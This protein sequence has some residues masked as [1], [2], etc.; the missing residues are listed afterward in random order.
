MHRKP[1]ILY[2]IPLAVLGGTQSHL[3]HLLKGFSHQY[4]IHLGIGEEGPLTEVAKSLNITVHLLPHL[5]RDINL[6]ADLKAIQET[7]ALIRSLQPDFIHTHNSKAGLVG[8][9]AGRLCGTPVIYT[10]HGWQFAAGTPL[11]HKV[12]SYINEKIGAFLSYK[13]ICVSE[14]DRKLA[15]RRF[16]SNRQK[17]VTIH[18]GIEDNNI[19][20]SHPDKTP[21]KVVMVARFDKQKD[22][23]TL[24]QSITQ[25]LH[26][27]FSVD[28]IGSGP[29]LPDCV[30][31]VEEL[32]LKHTVNFLGNRHDVP[33]I[34]SKAQL[35]VLSTNYE[36]LPI[37]ILEAMRAG[38]PV[39]A[40]DVD[41]IPE[42][43]IDGESGLLVP[44][45]DIGKMAYALEKLLSSPTIR[46]DMGDF[47]R[48]TFE[49]Q[50]SLKR[51]L[52]ETQS[53]YQEI[54]PA[55]SL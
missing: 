8:R 42:E 36:G 27:Q 3:C 18:L 26:L 23:F 10:A 14:S 33:E 30:A 28:L 39:V 17:I 49:N 43:V 54:I 52:Q 9:I 51:M 35:F 20:I 13:I 47:G 11:V 15:L 38:L 37:S 45:K 25:L 22:H 46:K 1:I 4:E 5:I 2:I 53:V 19:L 40:T 16:L 48:H 34:L 55:G 7:T 44:R 32:G 31:M 21:P 6:K 24:I 50:F 29:L 41:G 12:L